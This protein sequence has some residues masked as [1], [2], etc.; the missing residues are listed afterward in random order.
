MSI[1]NHILKGTSEL[2]SETQDLYRL[3]VQGVRDYAIFLLS[4]TGYVQTW[5]AGAEAIKGYKAEEIIGKHFSQF[6]PEE[7][8]AI[9]HPEMELEHATQHGSFEE[10][11][12]RVKKDGSLFWANVLITAIRSAKTGEL[13]GFSKVTR[14]LTDKKRL[15]DRL[16]QTLEELRRSEERARLLTE[17]ISDYAIFM[18][19]PQ[20]IVISWNQ[21]AENI[22]GYKA[23]EIIGKHFSAFYPEEANQRNY[24]EY[25]L[26]RALQDGRFEDEGLRVR[27]DGSTFWANV[28][29]TPV[30]NS[31]KQLIGFSKI[32]RDLSEK[33]KNEDLMRKN[34][35]LHRINTDLDNF[36]YTASH[37]LKAPISNLEGLFSLLKYD[38][39]SDLDKHQEVLSRIENSMARLNS[40]I[41]DLT[42]LTRIQHEEN[43]VEQVNLTEML[44]EVEGSL[45]NLIYSCN[46]V[47]DRD[48]SGFDQLNYSRKNLRSILFNLVSNAIKYSSPERRPIVKI[49][50][51][52][53]G[54]RYVL[55][56]S[57]NGL[58]IDEKY[59][60]KIFSMFR[61]LHTHVEGTGM[62]LYLV[63]RIL[64]NSGD[65]IELDSEPDKGSTFR[66]YFQQ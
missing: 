15:E 43:K 65:R 16:T 62:G 53:Q 48:L 56:V 10:E 39:G 19:N 11:G 34:K 47:V 60:Q 6:Y 13:L 31:E 3:L 4:P 28:L 42:D 63:K 21:G 66:L 22:K 51:E 41:L 30:Y 26:S 45:E 59:K 25:E 9:K 57:D 32:T 58:G 50:T 23:E 52:M 20:G 38:L 44:D 18:L 12:W 55:Q 24:T 36:V 8:K 17:G 49:K 7:A 29:I 5:N 27:K 33:K 64:D 61:R 2:L 40:I 35:E 54:G 37:D 14:D 1:E 46:A